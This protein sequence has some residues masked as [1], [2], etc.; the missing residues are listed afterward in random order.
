MFPQRRIVGGG[1]KA[2]FTMES[3]FPMEVNLR[4]SCYKDVCTNLFL[5]NSKRFMLISLLHVTVK[6]IMVSNG[7]KTTNDVEK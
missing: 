4:F 6:I 3:L 2:L 1:E 7:T 5:K